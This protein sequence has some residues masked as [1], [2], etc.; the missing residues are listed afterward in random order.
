M[1]MSNIADISKQA[2]TWLVL[3]RY[4]LAVHVGD[5]AG[6]FKIVVLWCLIRRIHAFSKE[7]KG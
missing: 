5:E 6:V 1:C 7:T 3:P 4:V 2:N